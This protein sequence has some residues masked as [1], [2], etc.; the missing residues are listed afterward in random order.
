MDLL[1]EQYKPGVSSSYA[2]VIHEFCGPDV[3]AELR[4]ASG[5]RF[6]A[7]WP[8]SAQRAAGVPSGV[9]WLPPLADQELADPTRWKVVPLEQFGCRESPAMIAWCN[10]QVG[11]PYSL[12]AAIDAGLQHVLGL[13]SPKPVLGWFCSEVCIAALKRCDGPLLAL[14]DGLCPTDLDQWL[15]GLRSYMPS[16]WQY[17]RLR[18]R[19][20]ARAERLGLSFTPIEAKKMEVL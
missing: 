8:S 1:F 7:L 4:V 18:Q 6:T 17:S 13:P 10:G 16:S 3:H 9:A 20:E 5:H 11:Q 15:A 12:R 14:P 2:A 19:M